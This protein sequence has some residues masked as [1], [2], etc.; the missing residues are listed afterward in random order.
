MEDYHQEE[1]RMQWKLQNFQ[2]RK[3]QPLKVF[4]KIFISNSSKWIR[5]YKITQIEIISP[6][7]VLRGNISPFFFVLSSPL[8]KYMKFSAKNRNL[9][10]LARANLDIKIYVW[11]EF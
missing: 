5:D 9:L 6:M 2:S 8:T 3:K 4:N 1:I 11:R 10:G 7:N